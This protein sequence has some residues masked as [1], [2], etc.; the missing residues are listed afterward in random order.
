VWNRKS[1]DTEERRRRGEGRGGRKKRN[2][3]TCRR[4]E[5]SKKW[6]MGINVRAGNISIGSSFFN[7]IMIIHLDSRLI[8]AE[9][10]LT[11][12]CCQYWY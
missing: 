9:L 5:S 12:D 10:V 7:S 1:E 2:K 3:G 11:V 6:K 4:K 8:L